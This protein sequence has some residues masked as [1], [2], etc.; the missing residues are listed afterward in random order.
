MNKEE[1][2]EGV[3]SRIRVGIE[4]AES[5]RTIMWDI[6]KFLYNQGGV[7][8][9]DKELPENPMVEFY[10]LV[11]SDKYVNLQFRKETYDEY[12][13][14]VMEFLKAGFTKTEPLI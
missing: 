10:K 11:T 12:K 14:R 4:S 3:E 1:I 2:R 7:I 6:M 8:K 5:P 13:A 9:V